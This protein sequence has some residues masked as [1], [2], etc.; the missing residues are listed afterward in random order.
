MQKPLVDALFS[1][2]TSSSPIIA[3]DSSCSQTVPSLIASMDE[4]GI[5]QLL[6]APCKRW[7]CERYWICGDIQFNEVLHYVAA[8]PERFYGL[9]PYNPHAIIESLQQVGSAIRDYDFRGV[10]VH[11]EGSGVSI[12]DRRMY[13]L[14]ALCVELCVP[15]MVQVLN[16]DTGNQVTA[17]STV[18]VDLPDLQLVAAWFGPL[19]VGCIQSLCDKHPLLSFI[20]D[21]DV[22]EGNRRVFMDFLSTTGGSCCMW[23]SNGLPWK[24][25]LDRIHSYSLPGSV[26]RSLLHDN[27]ARLFGLDR[28]V[29]AKRIHSEVLAFAERD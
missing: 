12:S 26:Q 25:L 24:S 19:D 28:P 6:L 29:R 8:H 21:G 7:R 22:A 20:I 3:A 14:Y 23:G 2:D 9:A 17:L 5:T 11:S 4:H 13:P 16:S 1:I 27:A 10:Y 15:V 18:L